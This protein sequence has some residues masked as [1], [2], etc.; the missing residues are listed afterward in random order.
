VKIEATFRDGTKLVT[1]H[2]PI[3]RLNGDMSLCFYGSFLPMPE[4]SSFQSCQEEVEFVPGAVYTLNKSI[5]INVGRNLMTLEVQN[6]SDRPIQ[7]GSHYNFIEANPYLHFDR[8]AS[9]GKRL[10]MYV[11]ELKLIAKYHS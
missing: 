9:Y 2:N 6:Y 3:C 11:Y 8:A 10:N 7:V 5:F 4:L 1:L